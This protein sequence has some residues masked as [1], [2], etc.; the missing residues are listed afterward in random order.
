MPR[1]LSE[2][3]NGKSKK[4]KNFSF[5]EMLAKEKRN[6]CQ[7]GIT[8]L[9]SYLNVSLQNFFTQAKV[10]WLFFE[11]KKLFLENISFT[12]GLG[13]GYVDDELADSPI[14]LIGAEIQASNSIKFITE[15][16]ILPQDS[17]SIISFGIRFFGDYLA[18]DF[19]LI[20][21]S[22]GFENDGFPFIPWIGFAYNF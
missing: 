14:L 5:S 22:E 15:N 17:P 1:I 12:G 2:M 6:M 20:T 19:A 10:L 16:W 11:V 9:T 3:C 4:E 7:F 18:A 21:T 8:T 13:W